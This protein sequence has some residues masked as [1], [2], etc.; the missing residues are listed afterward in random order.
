M[1]KIQAVDTETKFEL[2]LAAIRELLQQFSD[3]VTF[4]GGLGKSSTI[5]LI[6]IPGMC[7]L[8]VDFEGTMID[9][10]A[11]TVDERIRIACNCPESSVS[12]LRV[13]FDSVRVVCALTDE[14]SEGM[15]KMSFKRYLML[16][17][18]APRYVDPWFS[19]NAHITRKTICKYV[20]TQPWTTDLAPG[21]L[22]VLLDKV[23]EYRAHPKWVRG[24]DTPARVRGD[25]IL[26]ELQIACWHPNADHANIGLCVQHILEG[27][28]VWAYTL[29]KCGVSAQT[30]RKLS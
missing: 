23:L 2:Y 29:N 17:G 9:P 6:T 26:S 1:K 25:Q 19:V 7:R 24:G 20:S 28:P 18:E 12:D 22:C 27:S 14:A 4:D 11:A 8:T 13:N 3:Q 30:V 21:L 15:R 5:Q 16:A 10:S